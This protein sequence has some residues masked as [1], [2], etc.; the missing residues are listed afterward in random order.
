[1][2]RRLFLLSGAAATLCARGDDAAP[3]PPWLHEEWE[4]QDEARERAVPVRIYRPREV[5]GPLPLVLFSHGI[6]GSRR[7]Y[8]YLGQ[9]LAAQGFASLHVQH[10]GS[11][12]ALWGAGSPFGLIGRLQ[13]AAAPSEA[14]NRV[15]DLRFA[16]DRVLA[17]PSLALDAGRIAVAGHS[18]GANTSLLL[19]G[20]AVPQADELALADPRIRAAVLISSPPLHGVPEPERALAAVRLP[21]LHITATADDIVIP[22][23]RSGAH[24]RIALFEAI[25]SPLKS[26]AVF[27]GGSHSVFTDRANTG[28][29]VANPRIKQATKELVA[30]FLQGV[31][32][33]GDLSQLSPWR[34]RHQ[35]LLAR[36]VGPG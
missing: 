34:Q 19:A 5:Q 20:A 12:R 31:L 30:G 24:E 22:G 7:G 33:D 27:E 6:G 21:S 11:D 4:W 32:G 8:S 9:H 29:V 23:Y 16:L 15:R 36:W 1:M 35:E 2:K 10:V 3:P 13:A 26:L 18:Y 28:G 14:L 25:G 17:Q